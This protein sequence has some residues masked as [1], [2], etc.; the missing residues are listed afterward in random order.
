MVGYV[1]PVARATLGT[2]GPCADGLAVAVNVLGTQLCDL[3]NSGLVRWRLSVLIDAVA[4]SW[5][6]GEEPVRRHQIQ[7][8]GEE[9][10]GWRAGRDGRD[11]SRETTLSGANGHTPSSVGHDQDWQPYPLDPYSAQSLYIQRTR[12]TNVSMWGIS[13]TQ[14]NCAGMDECDP[15]YL[16][17]DDADIRLY[18][19]SPHQANGETEGTCRSRSIITG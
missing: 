3:M 13:S 6:K 10:P 11:P 9:W 17:H 1:A 5:R 8:W 16:L 4:E 2:T 7:P 15:V 12:E 14:S 18:R 19:Q